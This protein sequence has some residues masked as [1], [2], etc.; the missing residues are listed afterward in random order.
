MPISVEDAIDR[1]VHRLHR[2]RIYTDTANLYAEGIKG[3]LRL[4]RHCSK[5]LTIIEP[6]EKSI[7]QI[8]NEYNVQES[9]I[10]T[11]DQV[12]FYCI[13]QWNLLRASIDILAQ[14]I[15]ELRGLGIDER[16]VDFGRVERAVT[17]A[18]PNANL[19]RAL[20]GLKNSSAFKDLNEYRH[21]S[22]HRRQI[23]I[24]REITR[25]NQTLFGTPGYNLQ[26]SAS[27]A[28][29]VRRYLCNN[30]WQLKPRVNRD[31]SVGIFGQEL[32]RKIERRM[33]TIVNRLP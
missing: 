5:M 29:S 3:N 16:Q 15:N 30:P 17:T 28:V 21:C 24:Q 33:I 6:L 9:E 8:S 14:L 10:E 31:R 12:L 1:L 11:E 27:E 32:L 25:V 22:T 13:S 26:Y 23:F 18:A 19:K 4:A 7:L 20:I 2:Q